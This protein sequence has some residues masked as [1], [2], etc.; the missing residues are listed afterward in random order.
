[1]K[2]ILFIA[3][4]A[5]MTS[6]SFAQEKSEPQ[7]RRREFN[8]EEFAAMQTNMLNKAL[9]LDSIQ[10]QA[11]LLMNY[12]DALTMQDSMKVR[13][14]R[15]EKMRAN[16]EKPQQTRPDSEE[17]KARMELEKQRR[18]VRDNKLK[19]IL[20]PEQ[21]EKYIKMQEEQKERMR[22]NRRG[23]DGGRNWNRN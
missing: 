16:G 21:F 4:V 15:F 12:A 22:H 2:R 20:T 9:Q 1:M 11:V 18:E 10:Y 8:P 13:R 7:R 14:E 5:I 19:Q 17:R 23:R 3:V 6:A